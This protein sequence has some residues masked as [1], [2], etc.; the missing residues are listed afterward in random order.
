MK[1]SRL[2]VAA[3]LLVT[4]CASTTPTPQSRV[5]VLVSRCPEVHIGMT[6]DQATALMGEYEKKLNESAIPGSTS[7]IAT[8]RYAGMN[9]VQY[10]DGKVSMVSCYQAPQTYDRPRQRWKTGATRDGGSYPFV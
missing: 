10:T 7:T 9:M 6:F 1:L 5:V 2:I 8:Y 3:T 4:G